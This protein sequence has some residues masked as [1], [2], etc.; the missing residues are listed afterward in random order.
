MRQINE[1]IIHCTA[2]PEGLDYTVRDIDRWHRSRGFNEIGYH[3]IIHLNGKIDKGRDV[4][5]IGAHC[6]GHN[7]HTIGIAYIG[8]LR[9][10]KPA[11]TRTDDQKLALICLVYQLKKKYP[12]IT[13]VSGHNEYSHKACPCFKVPNLLKVNN[14]IV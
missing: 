7:R 3:Y 5:K 10:G 2:T 1:I 9:D 8:G 14:V 4:E 12:S 13:K 6:K 11:D